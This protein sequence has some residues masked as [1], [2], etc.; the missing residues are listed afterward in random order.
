MSSYPG[1]PDNRLIV[2]GVDLTTTYRMV[3]IDGYVL[4]P[5][6][7]KT[8]MVDIPGGNGVIDLTDSLTGDVLFSTRHQEFTFKLMFPE[9]FE[10]VK[11]QVSNF[12]HGK[13][14]D[15]KITMDPAYTY[16]GRFS[17]TSYSHEM[18]DEGKLGEIVISITAEPYKMLETKTYVL[19]APGGRWFTFLS[20]RKPVRPII[21]TN[22]PTLIRWKDKVVELGIGTYRLN[23]VLFTEGSNLIYINT[24]KVYDTRW[25]NL[26]KDGSNES[27]WNDVSDLTWDELQ[28]IRIGA[29]ELSATLWDDLSGKRWD[30]LTNNN[31]HWNDFWKNEILG[32][33]NQSKTKAYLQ[34][35]WGDL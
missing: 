19:D 26:M 13:E 2:G 31:V 3:L 4:S 27:T 28:R 12:L 24:Y 16:H 5:P 34:Y 15:Y 22:Y 6:E 30:D 10:K 1:Y 29:S 7:P 35:D 8:Y 18:Y 14:F 11:T 33:E 32:N 20:G 25:E 9:D 21:E 23:D 17:I